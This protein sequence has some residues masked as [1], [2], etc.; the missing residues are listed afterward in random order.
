[1]ASKWG[2]GACLALWAVSAWSAEAEVEKSRAA[3][4]LVQFKNATDEE[5]I[6]FS[7][8][9][10][11]EYAR[12]HGYGSLFDHCAENLKLGD[13]NENFS[14]FSAKAG[15]DVTLISAEIFTGMAPLTNK[16]GQWF[17]PKAIGF[18]LSASLPAESAKLRDYANHQLLLKD[19]GLFNGY[20]SAAPSAVWNGTNDECKTAQKFSYIA[21][22]YSSKEAE[23]FT[24]SKY[25]RP[26]IPSRSYL[27]GHP[28][29][30]FV[31]PYVAHGLG[32]KAINTDLEDESDE[33]G[34][35][36]DGGGIAAAGV[37]FLGLGA[38]GPMYDVS[39]F[40]V[41]SSS[42]TMDVLVVGTVTR[43]NP[44]T[45]SKLYK[46]DIDDKWVYSIGARF[47]VM[48]TGSVSLL[49]EYASPLGRSKDYIDD[50][51]VFSIAYNIGAASREAAEKEHK[52]QA[53]APAPKVTVVPVSP[54]G[55]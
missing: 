41:K 11:R 8:S 38:S 45:L 27:V 19:G 24:S 30:P 33:A 48:V 25:Q 29:V 37:F 12:H 14:E 6:G 26:F 28:V 39:K 42:G 21:R 18:E 1:M 47:S 55:Q 3:Q 9:D 53:E 7:E 2:V 46:Q 40:D 4:L 31:R 13:K 35:E 15:S 32:L 22:G 49:V 44:D 54:P 10:V 34:D 23:N 52:L 50:V 20:L 43:I 17:V 16:V 51:A 5:R 36:H